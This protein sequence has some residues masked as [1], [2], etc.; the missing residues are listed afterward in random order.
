MKARVGALLAAALVVACSTARGPE[1]RDSRGVEAPPAVAAPPAVRTPPAPAVPPT[2]PPPPSTGAELGAGPPPAPTPVPDPGRATR[3]EPSAAPAMRAAPGAGAAGV[4]ARP[5]APTST[6]A[7]DRATE[8]RGPGSEPP[9]VP[10]PVLSPKVDDEARVTSH[11]T[12]RLDQAGRVIDQID[13]A[14]L[15]PDQREMV[16]WIREFVSKAKDALSNKDYPRAEVLS[17][18]ASTLARELAPA[19]P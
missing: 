15:S 13:P 19:R 6:A 5:P 16:V 18:K 7:I 11:V 3:R 10:P 2:L 4:R 12:A 17:E 8:P 14:K 1:R 9:G